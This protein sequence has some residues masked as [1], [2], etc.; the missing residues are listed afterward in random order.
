MGDR[1]LQKSLATTAPPS[2]VH[3]AEARPLKDYKPYLHTSV[4][5]TADM[6]SNGEIEED[7]SLEPEHA[8]DDQLDRPAPCF[9]AKTDHDRNCDLSLYFNNGAPTVLVFYAA[10]CD[11]SDHEARLL[12][13]YAMDYSTYADWVLVS[14]ECNVRSFKAFHLE[15]QLEVVTHVA[16]QKE[17]RDRINEAFSIEYLPHR[18]FIDS[19]GLIQKTDSSAECDTFYDEVI[20]GLRML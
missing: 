11:A 7:A 3:S 19:D 12:E 6:D 4:L 18:V 10:W 1:V 13:K 15:C 14:V 20:R 2:A 17:E 9:T 5:R 8:F 16:L